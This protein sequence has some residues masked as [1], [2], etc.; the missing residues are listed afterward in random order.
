MNTTTPSSEKTVPAAPLQ[1]DLRD[2]FAGMALASGR[3][4]IILSEH[5]AQEAY[6]IA[7]A[8]LAARSKRTE[9]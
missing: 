8:M 6:G 7:D 1:L 5:L 9:P 4:N 2:W 3:I